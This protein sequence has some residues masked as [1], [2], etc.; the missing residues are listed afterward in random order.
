MY[1]AAAQRPLHSVITAATAFDPMSVAPASIPVEGAALS[2]S[3]V[4]PTVTYR[5]MPAALLANLTQSERERLQKDFPDG[6]IPAS[7]GGV[8]VQLANLD[9]S[10]AQDTSA[11]ANS[12]GAT[13]DPTDA[14]YWYFCW[15]T[16]F[17]QPTGNGIRFPCFFGWCYRER[18]LLFPFGYCLPGCPSPPPPPPRCLL[19]LQPSGSTNLSPA[20]C[21]HSQP[22]CRTCLPVTT[23]SSSVLTTSSCH[24]QTF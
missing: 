16:L 15:S 5:A 8:T 3:V 10:R 23:H 2:P 9:Y 13:P 4:A 11:C 14:R 18:N 22:A 21:P 12:I 1:P 20:V 24:L 17:L 19:L 6:K 7:D